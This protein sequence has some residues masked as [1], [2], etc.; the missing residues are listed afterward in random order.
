[1]VALSLRADLS[2]ETRLS[3]VLAKIVS[4]VKGSIAGSTAGVNEWKMLIALY[5]ESYRL[6]SC[7]GGTS[8]L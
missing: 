1:M 6:Q 8:E 3:A 4:V 5:E 2:E 7:A